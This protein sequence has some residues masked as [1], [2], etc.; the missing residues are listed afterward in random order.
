MR[1]HKAYILTAGLALL[2]ACAMSGCDDKVSD[3]PPKPQQDPEAAPKVTST[4]PA[5]DETAAAT[6]DRIAIVYDRKIYLPQKPQ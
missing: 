1:I 3:F 6:G 4:L 2:T 5:M